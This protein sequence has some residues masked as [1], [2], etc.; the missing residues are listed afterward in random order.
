MRADGLGELRKNGQHVQIVYV[1]T[2]YIGCMSR[3]CMCIYVYTKVCIDI[4]AYIYIYTHGVYANY[5]LH[6]YVHICV[7]MLQERAQRTAT[8]LARFPASPKF[9]VSG[10]G[11]WIWSTKTS[12]HHS[13]C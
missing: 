13:D 3:V 11:F 4:Y 7:A 5:V 10:S 2:K 6:A 12:F 8:R 1:K 9:R